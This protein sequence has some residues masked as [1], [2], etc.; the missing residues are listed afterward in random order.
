[1]KSAQKR[2]IESTLEKLEFVEWDRFTLWSGW[3]YGE[4]L[5]LYGWIEREEDS[6]KDFLTLELQC[7]EDSSV[8]EVGGFTTSSERY[9]EKINEILYS[10][11]VEHNPCERVENH[12]DVENSI[13]LEGEGL[14]GS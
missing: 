10:G 1:V 11:D 14:G 9:S 12:F 8:V 6:Y 13:E 5:T 4:I 7:L 2:K 3:R